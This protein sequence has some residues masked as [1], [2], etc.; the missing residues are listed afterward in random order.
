[1]NFEIGDVIKSDSAQYKIISNLGHGGNGQVFFVLALTGIFKGCYFA[2]KILY[3]INSPERIK[4][5]FYETSFLK[6]SSHVAILGHIDDGVYKYKNDEYPFVVTNYMKKN[7]EEEIRSDIP[8]Y[9]A[10]MYTTQLL[11]SLQYLHTRNLVHRDIKPANIFINNFQALL[12]DFGLLK[13]LNTEADEQDQQNMYEY[14]SDGN[15][16]AKNYKTPQLLMYAT[17]GKG[18]TLNSDIYQ[19]G[20][21]LHYMF[22]GQNAKTTING[23]NITLEYGTVPSQK[24]GARI[25][26][27]IKKMTGK[28]S[29]IPPINNLI[30]LWMQIFIDYTL[31]QNQLS[32]KSLKIY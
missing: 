30:S 13:Q 26:G 4:R 19:L 22:T 25:M 32:S 11:A 15:A 24:Y 10:L 21:V 28:E 3:K 17:T 1:M 14:Y 29:D 6:E 5:F 20:L 7:L 2:L 12:G 18:L 23:T 27:L 8:I 9:K 16:M 31:A